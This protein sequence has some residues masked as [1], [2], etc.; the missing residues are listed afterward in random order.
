[1]I[2]GACIFRLEHIGISCL[3]FSLTPFSPDLAKKSRH[4]RWRCRTHNTGDIHVTA[5]FVGAN[6]RCVLPAVWKTPQFGKP[7]TSEGYQTIHH[8]SHPSE[9]R[10][11]VSEEGVEIGDPNQLRCSTDEPG[12]NGVSVHHCTMGRRGS[13][14]VC[15]FPGGP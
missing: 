3:S 2:T 13:H 11:S 12:N 5:R 6:P 7:R 9:Q 10:T 14:P 8:L 4:C 15:H 1:M